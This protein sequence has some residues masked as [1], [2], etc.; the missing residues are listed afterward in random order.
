MRSG[1]RKQ[2][3]EPVGH[4]AEDMGT[5]ILDVAGLGVAVGPASGAV[6]A[7]LGYWA[8]VA[9]RPMPRA[10]EPGQAKRDSAVSRVW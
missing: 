10:C 4:R 3:A 1:L 8:V 6:A 7:V 5:E 2:T 9:V